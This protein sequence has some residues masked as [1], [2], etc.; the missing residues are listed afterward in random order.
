MASRTAIDGLNSI[1]IP[2]TEEFGE[3]IEITVLSVYRH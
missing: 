1:F 2:E 3:E